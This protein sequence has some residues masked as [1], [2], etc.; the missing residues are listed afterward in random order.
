MIFF[1]TTMD[2]I[3]ETSIFLTA[4]KKMLPLLLKFQMTIIMENTKTKSR[5]KTDINGKKQTKELSKAG[6]WFRDHPHGL[7]DVIINDRRIL[8]GLSPFDADYHLTPQ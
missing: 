1:C 8:Y 4:F 5:E 6:K 7:G 2:L 3:S